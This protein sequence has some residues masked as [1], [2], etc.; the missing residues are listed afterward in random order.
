MV[1]AEYEKPRVLSQSWKWLE[2]K[3]LVSRPNDQLMEA[4]VVVPC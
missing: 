1:R 3:E 4:A 2:L